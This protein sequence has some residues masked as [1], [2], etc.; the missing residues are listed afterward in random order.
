MKESKNPGFYVQDKKT[1]TCVVR[2]NGETTTY[3]A[4]MEDM[5]IPKEVG[6]IIDAVL[7]NYDYVIL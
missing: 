7:E 3:Q 5:S 2:L 1:G 4:H 6:Y